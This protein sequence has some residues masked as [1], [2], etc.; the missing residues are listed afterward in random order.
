[1]G[2]ASVVEPRE[3]AGTAAWQ[4]P[5]EPAKTAWQALW[6]PDPMT[7]P[8]RTSLLK[9][10]AFPLGSHRLG[11]GAEQGQ[12]L[13]NRSGPAGTVLWRM[14]RHGCAFLSPIQAVCSDQGLLWNLIGP[15]ANT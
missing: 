9:G 1:M 7:L 13:T 3:M 2:S 5:T 12:L 10:K 8:F 11:C 15:N 14:A 4:P 6:P